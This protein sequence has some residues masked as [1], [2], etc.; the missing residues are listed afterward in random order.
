[1]RKL[2]GTP[3]DGVILNRVLGPSAV[4]FAGRAIPQPPPVA[5][6]GTAK[7]DFGGI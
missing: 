1:M 7:F 5:A 4:K 6:T 3:S 2:L